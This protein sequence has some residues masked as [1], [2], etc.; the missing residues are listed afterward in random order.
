[1]KR[2]WI[3]LLFILLALIIS[4][5]A[6]DYR[7][8]ITF[9][10]IHEGGDVFLPEGE[11]N[12][13]IIFQSTWKLY[14]GNTHDRF[15]KMDTSDWNY[16]WKNGYWDKVWGDNIVNQELAESLAEWT[17]MSGSRTPIK[18]LQKVL[19]VKQTGVMNNETLIAINKE[20]DVELYDNFT[21]ERF[22]YI[23]SLPLQNPKY[24]QFIDGWLFREIDLLWYQ[25]TTKCE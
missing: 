11:T 20:D 7:R 22:K 15:L 10:K 18:L 24:R 9:V 23:V 1:M 17:W 19:R 12:E 2:S 6:A 3:I 14:Y 21:K 4:S 5:E 8:I 16:I 25:Y 13:G